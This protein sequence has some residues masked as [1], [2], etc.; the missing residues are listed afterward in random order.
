MIDKTYILIRDVP[1]E[2][3]P[4]LDRDFKNGETVYL[5]TGHTY[6]CI[7]YDGEA[8]TEVEGVEPFF[9]LPIDSVKPLK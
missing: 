9:E 5:Y 2:E 4:W 7:S 6:G 3:C 8:F 1:V